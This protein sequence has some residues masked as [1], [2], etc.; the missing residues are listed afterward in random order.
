MAGNE[1][2]EQWPGLQ[3]EPCSPISEIVITET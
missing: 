1:N 2:I 3:N